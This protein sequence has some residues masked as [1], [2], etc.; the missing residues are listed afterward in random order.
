MKQYYILAMAL[1]IIAS[2]AMGAEKKPIKMIT[3]LPLKLKAVV[4]LVDKWLEYGTPESVAGEL[5]TLPEDLRNNI[6]QLVRMKWVYSNT[7]LH[8]AITPEQVKIL[9]MLGANIE[10]K[11]NL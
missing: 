5:K 10:A 4:G 9:L 6:K 1:S 11:N 3:P 7:L 2:T 8:L